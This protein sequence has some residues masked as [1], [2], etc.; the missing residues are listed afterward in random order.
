MEK[1][2]RAMK[3]ADK[4]KL[5]KTNDG[6]ESTKFEIVPKLEDYDIDNLA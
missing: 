4:R 3:R 1:R 6:N 2:R 5:L